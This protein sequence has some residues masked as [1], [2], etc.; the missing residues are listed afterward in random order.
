VGR[1][2][3]TPE[4]LSLHELDVGFHVLGKVDDIEGVLR[5]LLL[6]LAP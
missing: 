3:P 1:A 4:V 6:L 2:H 5:E